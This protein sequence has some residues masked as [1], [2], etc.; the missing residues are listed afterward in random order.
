MIVLQPYEI[1]PFLYY[2]PQVAR[3]VCNRVCDIYG[4]V[5][6]VPLILDIQL[7]SNIFLRGLQVSRLEK[8]QITIVSLVRL[9]ITLSETKKS[10][11]NWH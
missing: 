9:I 5:P 7:D 11:T 3:I 1:K 4:R 10:M 2:D 8:P 6:L